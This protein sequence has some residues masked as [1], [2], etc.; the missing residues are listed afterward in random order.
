MNVCVYYRCFS[1]IPFHHHYHFFF[2]ILEIHP[3][4]D[5]D[6]HETWQTKVF[7]Y[8]RSNQISICD[9][10]YFVYAK[11]DLIWLNC[12][13]WPSFSFLFFTP[14]FIDK[15]FKHIFIIFKILSISPLYCYD[16]HFYCLIELL[17]PYYHNYYYYHFSLTFSVYFKEILTVNDLSENACLHVMYII[18]LFL[19]CKHPLLTLLSRHEILG[20]ISLCWGVNAG[21]KLFCLREYWASASWVDKNHF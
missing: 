2:L 16:N 15:Y 10:L 4:K 9:I 18:Y 11:N 7:L 20:L 3:L 1:S 5:P 13:V 21:T 12:V 6:H 14:R 19:I 17:F 8:I